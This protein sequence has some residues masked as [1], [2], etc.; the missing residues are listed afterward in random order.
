MIRVS[1]R[2]LVIT[3]LATENSEAHWRNIGVRKCQVW[4]R[5]LITVSLFS[6]DQTLHSTKNLQIFICKGLLK[7]WTK[8]NQFYI[9]LAVFSWKCVLY[10]STKHGAELKLSRHLPICTILL[11]LTIFHT[12]LWHFS[13]IRREV[14]EQKSDITRIL[15]GW[16]CMLYQSTSELTS[17]NRKPNRGF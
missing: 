15:I 8:L 3:K 1:L 13:L 12:S 7:N 2:N 11:C 6:F 16:K 14:L 9:M 17:S 5:F 4:V 10:Q